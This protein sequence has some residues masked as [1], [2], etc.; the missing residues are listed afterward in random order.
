[1]Y[2]LESLHVHALLVVH[3]P[4]FGNDCTMTIKNQYSITAA[5]KTIC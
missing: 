1:L 4:Q 5:T 2:H 3:V